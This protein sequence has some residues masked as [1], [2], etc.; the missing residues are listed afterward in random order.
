MRAIFRKELVDHFS[1]FRIFILL[2]LILLASAA[3]IYAAFHGI[4]GAVGETGFVFL[5]W[6]T[7]G[8][9]MLPSLVTFIALFVPIIGIALGFDAINSEHSSGTLSRILSQPIFRDSVINGKFLAGIVTLSIM[10]TATLLIVTGASLRFTGVP[11]TSEEAF[12][13]LVYLILIII[14]GAFWMGLSMLFSVLFRRT[15]TSLLTSI[16]LW[17]FFSFFIIMIA[18]LIANAL[19]PTADGT[20][21]ALIHN[22]QLQQAMLRFSPSILFEEATAVLLLPQIR[23]LGVITMSQAG[24]MLAN[25][26]SFSQSMLLACPHITSLVSLAIICFAISYVVFMRQEIRAT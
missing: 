15:A 7:T 8:G 23:S 20:E 10:M 12:R 6:F 22:Y 21:A 16:A 4:R 3:G 9:G 19:A 18:P 14:Y 11:P 17:L 13:L 24:G 25:P 2:L 5:K 26:L 1:S